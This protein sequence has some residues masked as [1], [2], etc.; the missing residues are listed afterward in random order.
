MCGT[1]VADILQRSKDRVSEMSIVPVDRTESENSLSDGV[2]TLLTVK[3]DAL[4]IK[5]L[6]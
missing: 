4:T 1:V 5:H 2:T 6:L 3:I